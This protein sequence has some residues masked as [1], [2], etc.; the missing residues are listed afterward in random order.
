MHN[1]D[2]SAALQAA[3]PCTTNE[4]IYKFNRYST[5][6]EKERKENLMQ[7]KRKEVLIPSEGPQV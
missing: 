5:R 7:V 6:H 4:G 2:S 1:I 3:R